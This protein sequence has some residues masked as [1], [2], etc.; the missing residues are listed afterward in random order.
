M[1][2]NIHANWFLRLIDFKF[3][4]LLDELA[5][6]PDFAPYIILLSLSSRE[7]KIHKMFIVIE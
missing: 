4:N 5:P 7:L 3:P 2:T 1:K 6:L